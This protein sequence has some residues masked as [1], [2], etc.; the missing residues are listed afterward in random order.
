MGSRRVGLEVPPVC[1]RS[2]LG[3][4]ARV[5]MG[6]LLSADIGGVGG[7]KKSIGVGERGGSG[8]S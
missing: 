2:G 4:S 3:S 5:G 8:W 6:T 7:W 1:A